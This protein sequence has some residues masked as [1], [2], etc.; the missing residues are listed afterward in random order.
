MR[1][2][3]IVTSGAALIA[4]MAS[5]SAQTA[6]TDPHVHPL[7][8]LVIN[9]EA[10]VEPSHVV[11]D[12]PAA[13]Q[14]T[15][16]PAAY[17]DAPNAMLASPPAVD[18]SASA[19]NE[20]AH[21]MVRSPAAAAEPLRPATVPTPASQSSVPIMAA[22][23]EPPAEKPRGA[24]IWRLL[25]GALGGAAIS[26]AL[27]WFLKRKGAG[28]A[29]LTTRRKEEAEQAM[30]SHPASA[31][32]NRRDNQA[33]AYDKRWD[34]SGERREADPPW[35]HNQAPGYDGRRPSS[36]QRQETDPRWRHD[37]A[38]QY[39]SR[40]DSRERRKGS[41]PRV[42]KPAA[43]AY[44]WLWDALK[45]AEETDQTGGHNAASASGD[46][47]D[48]RPSSAPP[49]RSNSLDE[50]GT[51]LPRAAETRQRDAGKV[52]YESLEQEITSLLGRPTGKNSQERKADQPSGD[53]AA[54]TF[55]AVGDAF[56]EWEA[57]DHPSSHSAVSPY[58]AVRSA[59]PRSAPPVEL[60]PL[61]LD[62]TRA[63]SGEKFYDSDEITSLLGRST[64]KYSRRG[65]ADRPSG[66]NTASAYDA[67]RGALRW[68]D[69]DDQPSGPNRASTPDEVLDDVVRKWAQAGQPGGGG[70]ASAYDA[71]RDALGE[72]EEVDQPSNPNRPSTAD[73]ALGDAL[74][75]WAQADQPGGRSSASAYDA[76]RDAP[77][78][79]EEVD[80]PGGQGSASAYDAVRDALS[81]TEEVDQPS[82]PNRASTADEALG[83]AVRKWARGKPRHRYKRL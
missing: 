54:S 28:R 67:V 4:A 19:P 10:I 27:V 58:D 17:V 75:K 62:T 26:A 32:D 7:S 57:G 51:T 78:E 81:E 45:D 6:R 23:L 18:F 70:S 29:N 15:A 13:M 53:N 48:A 40:W 72:A 33:S 83:D 12:R 56:T 74:R 79:T 63:D 71:V 80:Q 50:L 73:E 30:R 49:V 41:Q 68:R 47:R 14:G 3:R 66:R 76:V 46:V 36:N 34:D 61:K 8:L 65:K 2:I 11:A 39:N 22:A 44:D 20:R 21:L 25:I 42:Y 1:S 16:R 77:S 60:N 37:Q 52:R 55:D 35:R 43:S 82:G 69:D 31:F 5:A 38:S 24:Q 9:G 64:G 59:Q